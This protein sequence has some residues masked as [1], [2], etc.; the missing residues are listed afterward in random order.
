ME[1]QIVYVCGNHETL[2]DGRIDDCDGYVGDIDSAIS[3]VQRFIDDKGFDGQRRSFFSDWHGGRFSRAGETV[4][5]VKYGYCRGNVATL[6]PDP[7]PELIAVV[8]AAGNMLDRLLD[9]IGAR[10]KEDK[11]DNCQDTH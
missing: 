5:G 1:R 2:R 9:E 11:A 6:V 4:C 10:E 7:S 3:D 8:N